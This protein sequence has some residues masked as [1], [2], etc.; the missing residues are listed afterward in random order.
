VQ[1]VPKV[2]NRPYREII[3]NYDEIVAAVKA[4]PFQEFAETI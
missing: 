2:I 4:S 3:E 1:C